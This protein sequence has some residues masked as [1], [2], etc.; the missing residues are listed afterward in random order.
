MLEPE[1]YV[2]LSQYGIETPPWRFVAKTQEAAAAADEV[3]YPVVVK[4]VS[5]DIVH[6]S[7]VGA[8]RVGIESAEDA[9]GRATR[10]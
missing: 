3:G 9:V 10:S 2:L 5:R 8:V 1:A 6:K 7:D 4:A